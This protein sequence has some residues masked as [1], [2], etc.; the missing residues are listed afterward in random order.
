MAIL[1]RLSN[2]FNPGPQA[3][4][5]GDI[6]IQR[7]VQEQ[8]QQASDRLATYE[9]NLNND[10]KRFEQQ[11]GRNLQEDQPGYD[12]W[13]QTFN[14]NRPTPKDYVYVYG[15]EEG[16]QKLN[17]IGLGQAILGPGK[18]FD[19]VNS[20]LNEQGELVP[21][22]RVADAD[23]GRFYSA[24]FTLDGRKFS[25][26]VQEAS[27]DG[28]AADE[29]YAIDLKALDPV[30]AK[31]KTDVYNRPQAE[32]FFEAVG[33]DQPIRWNTPEARTDIL[34]LL[35]SEG[36]L[37]AQQTQDTQDLE[38]AGAPTEVV[39]GEPAPT[40]APMAASN[41]VFGS[42]EEFKRQFNKIDPKQ[43]PASGR[44]GVPAG[45]LT[46]MPYNLNRL[47]GVDVSSYLKDSSTHP[48]NFSDNDWNSMTSNEQANAIK[49]ENQIHQSNLTNAIVEG[50]NQINR[51]QNL[52][53]VKNWF[54]TNE[55]KLK[56]SFENDQKL[57]EEFNAGP[58][59]FAR[60][61]SG[62]NQNEIFG[63]PIAPKTVNSLKKESVV[64]T[65]LDDKTVKSIML[66]ASNQDI[67][68]FTNQIQDLIASDK[69]SET[70]Q[71]TLASVL[72]QYNNNFQR[73]NDS[74]R[75]AMVGDMAASL[76]KESL[77]QFMPYM[78]RFAQS[79]VLNFEAD[80]LALDE[81][82]L[83]QDQLEFETTQAQKALDETAISKDAVDLINEISPIDPSDIK[84]KGYGQRVSSVLNRAVRSGSASDKANA[85]DALNIF[86]SKAIENIA[87]RDTWIKN[88]LTKWM[89]PK[90]PGRE[91]QLP[92]EVRAFD[93]EDNPI[94]T[95]EDANNISYFRLVGVGDQVVGEPIRRG[96]LDTDFGTNISEI[97]FYQ[98]LLG[99]K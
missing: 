88:P 10:L 93:K 64:S 68:S 58:Y 53:K 71:Q 26:V 74:T 13:R 52:E 3:G 15:K 70:G 56:T 14:P 38:A 31:F 7:Q 81:A 16:L 75:L 35:S 82:K 36:M 8:K 91:L 90:V 41:P 45:S 6:A 77:A 54:K 5:R 47:E 89:F 79:G 78:M 46:G 80:Q 85:E 40:P 42:V 44:L 96:E 66:A 62:V 61:Y 9:M 76:S 22:V 37:E 99:R 83:A 27:P 29:G 97:L 18:Q 19:P 4:S 43:K 1:D 63:Q 92:P 32:A 49:L 48:L 33:Y 84:G 30:F 20:Y 23:Q 60:K 67:V 2:L 28:L 51:P 86:I 21:F 69:L 55:S 25:E 59:A 94:T 34:N 39:G 72:Q 98:S 24:P 50:R 95:I 57:F 65:K 87:N 73:A 11:G 12:N 17:E